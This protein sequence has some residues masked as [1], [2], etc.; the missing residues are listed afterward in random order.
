MNSSRVP[1]CRCKD[2]K[3][4]QLGGVQAPLQAVRSGFN[5][6]PSSPLPSS[7]EIASKTQGSCLNYFWLN[8]DLWASALSWLNCVLQEQDGQQATPLCLPNFRCFPLLKHLCPRKSVAPRNSR[9]F[10][11]RQ[12]GTSCLSIWRRSLLFIYLIALRC[13][14]FEGC[15]EAQKVPST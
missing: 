15:L 11:E 3:L 10:L 8:A 6:F 4:L 14:R 5:S 2:R 1:H 7:P 12:R 13:V 9:P